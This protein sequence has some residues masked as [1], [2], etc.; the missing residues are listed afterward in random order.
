MADQLVYRYYEVMCELTALLKKGDISFETR[1]RVLEFSN[2]KPITIFLPGYKANYMLLS[3]IISKFVIR[4]YT[5]VFQNL[6][7]NNGVIKWV[8]VIGEL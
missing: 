4:Q 3:S 1:A 2:I 8:Q 5:Y 6:V 7:R